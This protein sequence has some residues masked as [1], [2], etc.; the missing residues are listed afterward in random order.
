MSNVIETIVKLPGVGEGFRQAI[1]D[2]LNDLKYRTLISYSWKFNM[3]EGTLTTTTS[4]EYTMKG[5]TGNTKGDLMIID[6]IRY[7]SYRKFLIYLEPTEFDMRK[8]GTSVD[9]ASV[10]FFT[11]RKTNNQR[12]PIIEL[13]GTMTAG[14]TIY[15]DYRK[16]PGNDFSEMFPDGFDDV[17]RHYLMSL[18]LSDPA[19]QVKR[20]REYRKALG[21]MK[22]LWID[23]T[24]KPPVFQKLTTQQMELA[25]CLNSRYY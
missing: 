4:Q 3:A 20:E 2:D 7:S 18:W 16:R 8:S 24:T 13:D 6:T 15:F 17:W 25:E 5:G 9:T 12:Y 19:L 23:M 22:R 11:I 1:T 21:D 14:E 10:N